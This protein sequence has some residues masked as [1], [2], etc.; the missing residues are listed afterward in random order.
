MTDTS[1][2]AALETR[3]SH[4]RAYL[5]QATKSSE[6][7]LRKVWI[8]QIEREIAAEIAFLAKRGVIVRTDHADD[9]SDD[10]LLASLAD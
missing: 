6:I 4:E 3:L 8:A 10:D 7:E 1:H 2:L 9:I 5:A